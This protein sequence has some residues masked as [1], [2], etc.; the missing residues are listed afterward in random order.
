MK[1]GLSLTQMAEELERQVSYKRDF[2][3]PN[4]KVSMTV[5]VQE[6]KAD[7]R[8]SLDNTGTFLVTDYAHG[9]LSQYTGI[10]KAY[11][12]RLRA[13]DPELLA[14]NVN[15]WLHDKSLVNEKRMIRTL[16]A[17]ARAFL[18][19]RYR[20]LDNFDLAQAALPVLLKQGSGLRVESCDLTPSRMYIKAVT[21]CL[22]TEVKKGD[23][24]QAGIVIS[25]SE[26]GAGSV[27]IEPMIFRLI[28]LNGMISADSSLRKYHVGRN[29]GGTE[30]GDVSQFFRDATREADDRAFFMKV[31]DVISAAFSRDI[32]VRLVN[33][34]TSAT[35]RP[36]T[37][38]PVEVIDVTAKRFN[39]RDA[40]KTSVLRKLI[41][42]AD[43][44]QYGLLNAVTSAAQDKELDYE[45]ATELER[46]G[47]EIIELSQTEWKH[48]AEAA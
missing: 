26:I 27:K 42:G 47:G 18:S 25:N 46:V 8:I 45:R 15:R 24:V 1:T 20:P 37:G 28:C 38:D 13:N 19:D 30:A 29:H 6:N 43:L 16:D 40:E 32:F 36:I 9:Q 7:V 23:V 3:A 5:A 10:P 33:K 2:V 34:M 31:A 12:D 21:E 35:E 14:R 4:E 17:S 11:Y 48:I 41:E 44:S 22:T 39:L